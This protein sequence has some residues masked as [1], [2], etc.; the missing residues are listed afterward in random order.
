MDYAY[1]AVETGSGNVVTWTSSTPDLTGAG[2]GTTVDAGSVVQTN[3]PGPADGTNGFAWSGVGITGSVLPEDVVLGA[4]LNGSW[5]LPTATLTLTGRSILD[6]YDAATSTLIS[7]DVERIYLNGLTGTH[8]LPGMMAISATQAT[9]H[10][11]VYAVTLG[12]VAATT[13]GLVLPTETLFDGSPVLLTADVR[14]LVAFQTDNSE[15]GIYR[16]S[17]GILVRATD[18]IAIGHQIPVEAG[19]SWA[20]AI[21]SC[22]ATDTYSPPPG[23]P[24]QSAWL[25]VAPDTTVGWVEVMT[26]PGVEGE[27]AHWYHVLVDIVASYCESVDAYTMPITRSV[28]ISAAYRG[29]PSGDMVPLGDPLAFGLPWEADGD[30]RLRAV[31]DGGVIRIDAYRDATG[32]DNRTYRYKLEVTRRRWQV[33]A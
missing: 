13:G 26:I 18:V 12:N 29:N 16:V 27:Y 25:S 15:N 5:D 10:A 22:S 8:L 23:S 17:G 7:A 3:W 19:R 1:Q 9:V 6:V 28:R 30:V 31:V 21:W 24:T 33:L 32:G 20:G 14:V 2:S 4:G 11:P